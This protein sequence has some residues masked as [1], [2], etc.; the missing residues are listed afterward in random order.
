MRVRSDLIC[1]IVM[2]A[3]ASTGIV[4]GQNDW[5]SFGHDPGAQRY[6]ALTQINAGN[7]TRLMQAWTYQTKP[8]SA[9]EGRPRQSN[10]SP[11]VINGVLYFA[12]PY[13]SLVAVEP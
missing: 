7:V 6:S 10:T 3:A 8:P 13:Q 2:L 1:S 11:L 4:Y 9:G 5:T 12:T